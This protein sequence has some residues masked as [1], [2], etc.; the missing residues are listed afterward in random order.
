MKFAVGVLLT[1][2]GVFWVLEGAGVSWPGGEASA[3]VLI[4]L[5]A[6]ASV[7]ATKLLG[8]RWN[9]SPISRR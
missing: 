1:S 5:T 4:L 6:T 3:A 8:R 7:A 2:F 9:P